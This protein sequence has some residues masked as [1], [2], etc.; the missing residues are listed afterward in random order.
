MDYAGANE[1]AYRFVNGW[2]SF[3]VKSYCHNPFH[4]KKGPYPDDA[5][6]FCGCLNCNYFDHQD[7]R[8]NEF[9]NKDVPAMFMFKLSY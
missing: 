1:T 5:A 4:N 2:L 9:K 6:P 3:L 8:I 7:S